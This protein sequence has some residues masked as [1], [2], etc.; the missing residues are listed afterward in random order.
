MSHNQ[1]AETTLKYSA[2]ELYHALFEQAADGLFIIDAQGRCLEVN[3]S[4]YEMLGYTREEMLELDMVDLLLVEDPAQNLLRL[5][6]LNTDKILFKERRLRG[7]DGRLLPVEIGV[8][9]LTDGRLLAIVHDL[10]AQEQAEQHI[11]LLNFALNN[12]H[13]AAFLIDEQARFHYVNEES[14]QVLGYTQDELVGMRV[15]DIDPDFPAERWLSHWQK[16]KTHQS[17][18]FESHH[19]TKDGRIFPVAISASYFEYGGQLYTLALARDITRRKQAEMEIAR[20]NRALRMLSS[21]NQALIHATDEARLLDEVCQIAVATGGY[22]MAWVG[23][24]EQ[25]EAKTVRPITYA[26]FEE[27]YLEILDL[28]WAAA[29]RG[30]GPV[31]TAIRT[32]KPCVVRNIFNSPV[33]VY[34]SETAVQRGYYA[35]AALPLL[36]DNHVLGTLTI[37]AGETEAFDER[38]VEIL[39]ELAGDLAFGITA[40]RTRLKQE[41]AEKALRASEQ[42]AQSLVRLSRQLEQAQTYTEVLDAA[43]VAVKHITGYKDLWVYLIAEDKKSCRALVA[44]GSLQETILSEEGFATLTITG[45]RFLEELAQTREIMIIED[46]RTDARTNKEI[47][48][49]LENRTIVNVPIILFDKH[50]GS[51]GTG[52]FGAD[53]VR[54]PTR[55]EQEFLIAVASH[56]TV[57]LDRVNALAARERANAA[58]RESENRYRIVADN[59]YDWEFWISPDEQFLYNSPSCLRITGYMADE[60]LRDPGLLYRI[61][62]PEDRHP[63]LLHEQRVMEKKTAGGIEFRIL[64]ADGSL[65]YIGHVCQPVY[66]EQERYLGKR[67]SNRDITERKRAEEEL[68]TLS[69][70][71]EQSPVVIVITNTDG[72]IEYVNPRFTQ[73]SGYTRDEVIGKNPR[74][75]KSGATDQPAYQQLWHTI[76]DGNMWQ[77]EFHNKKKNG[78]L[79]WV[80]TSISPVHD[81]QGNIRHF[82]A[83]QE[84][85]TARKQRERALEAMVTVAMALRAA[86]GRDEA[87]YIVVNQV[88]ELLHMGGAALLLRVPQSDDLVAVSA[89]GAW[90]HWTGLHFPIDKGISGRVIATGQPYISDNVQAD[91]LLHRKELIGDLQK[92]I[93]VPLIAEKETIG[94]LWV[95]QQA[96]ITPYD[97]RLLKAIAD[98]AAMAIWRATLYEQTQQYAAELEARVAA[99][100]QELAQAN[101]RLLELDRLKTKFVSDV[102][103]ELR[104]PITNLQLYL[105]LLKHGKPEKR[106]HHLTVLRQQANRLTRLVEDILDLSRLELGDRRIAFASVDLNE[107]VEQVVMTHQPLADNAN[108]RLTFEPGPGLPF[109][110]GEVNQLAQV[111]TNLVANALNYTP[112]GSVTVRTYL[113][114]KH[115]CL[116]VMD[117]GIG[118]DPEDLPHLFE[119]FYRGKQVSQGVV[120]GTGLGL[121][122]VKEIVDLHRGSIEVN[123]Q[124]GKG[125]AFSVRL[126][127]AE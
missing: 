63:F 30:L 91:T 52:T 44:G 112:V 57:S 55:A 119:R 35:I 76:S 98:M 43:A 77:G 71:I 110:Q 81:A 125:S 54:P 40:L 24:A 10:S 89:C 120:P 102:S 123:S 37:Y 47:V 25:D 88:F 64:H 107:L 82:V 17:L 27:G 108:L 80:S 23:F 14:C 1:L 60:F 38:E 51:V 114:E 39:N 90:D 5:A 42:H 122:I 33:P 28:T 19:K 65:R 36:S 12:I 75:L 16:L 124:G 109:V 49:Q 105:D 53:G 58:L 46:A 66:D 86:A 92:V 87:G 103:H 83:V 41:Q 15:E 96:P 115:V 62:H 121:A 9:V 61:I 85:I 34:W 106:D 70:A 94:V 84:D 29:G 8:Q 3:H 118:I 127:F 31:G 26:G 100:T 20:I 74:I 72:A 7:K 111:V 117:T 126:P 67:G 2:E 68:R 97:I 104:T 56:M 6:D 99:R 113:E 11:A 69:H 50:I 21:T 93:C 95:G 48:A 22:R 32:Q 13:E 73:L 101:E 78:E 18:M 45:D 79:Y 4:G 59:T 116:N